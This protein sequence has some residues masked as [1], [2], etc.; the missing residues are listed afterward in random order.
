MTTFHHDLSK[1]IPGTD[2]WFNIIITK[3]A[4]RLVWAIDSRKSEVLVL[5]RMSYK[6]V[7]YRHQYYVGDHLL[8]DDAINRIMTKCFIKINGDNQLFRIS[9]RESN[10]QYD[11]HGHDYWSKS[12]E[13]VVHIPKYNVRV[14]LQ[15]LIAGNTKVYL[16][17]SA[18]KILSE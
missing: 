3:F 8:S 15:D 12:L 17:T 16:A 4:G 2:K 5:G 1:E 7:W 14:P 18:D 11:D 6:S 13:I 9:A 10:Y